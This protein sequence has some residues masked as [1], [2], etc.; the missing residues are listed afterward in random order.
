MTLVEAQDLA[1]K[2][3]KQVMEEKLDHN[4]VQLAQVRAPSVPVQRTSTNVNVCQVV[5]GRGFSI[6]NQQELKEVITRANV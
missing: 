2:V 5:P 4:N 3:L 1:L 6:L